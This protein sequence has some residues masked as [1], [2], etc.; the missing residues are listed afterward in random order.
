[1]NEGLPRKSNRKKLEV[2]PKEI[3]E[4]FTPTGS[5]FLRKKSSWERTEEPL[6]EK[7]EI[8]KKKTRPR[9]KIENIAPMATSEILPIDVKE[10]LDHTK[11]TKKKPYWK[12]SE[13]IPVEPVNLDEMTLG[14]I[15]GKDKKGFSEIT[16]AIKQLEES[17]DIS[18]I[19][20]PEYEHLFYEDPYGRITDELIEKE[21]SETDPVFMKKKAGS[22]PLDNFEDRQ[23]NFAD[24]EK[25]ATKLY[26]EENPDRSS[27][28]Y[29]QMIGKKSPKE[30]LKTTSESKKQK[31]NRG[32]L[33]RLWDKFIPEDD[34]D[35]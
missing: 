10:D 14:E 27:R 34:Y 18:E 23:R 19:E 6:V 32:F 7:K 17:G 9:K 5:G 11:K 29:Y 13:N 33:G 24:Q 1:M 22:D 8:V 20:D 30:N 26:P 12:T 4:Q 25:Y 2:S 28:D 15:I 35:E 21:K 16:D 3:L 31:E